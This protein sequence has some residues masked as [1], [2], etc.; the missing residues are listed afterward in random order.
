MAKK[1]VKI[2]LVKINIYYNDIPTL[3]GVET[4]NEKKEFG[5]TGLSVLMVENRYCFIYYAYDYYTSDIQRRIFQSY[6]IRDWNKHE[7]GIT[8]V[9]IAK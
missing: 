1:N 4:S 3:F 2:K 8:R 5:L 6:K 9:E 7:D